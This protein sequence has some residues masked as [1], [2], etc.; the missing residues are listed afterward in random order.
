MEN[1]PQLEARFRA[2]EEDELADATGAE[3]SR[4]AFFL[5]KRI[6]KGIYIVCVYKTSWVCRSRG[7]FYLELTPSSAADIYVICCLSI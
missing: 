2:E 6:A 7:Y 5:Q 3:E 4:L 1:R